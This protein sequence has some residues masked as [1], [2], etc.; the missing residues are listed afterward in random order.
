MACLPFQG[1]VDI[2]AHVNAVGL[3][4][5]KV[6]FYP[7]QS[8]LPC[9]ACDTCILNRVPENISNLSRSF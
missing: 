3:L 6:R 5:R 1:A 2:R 9:L 4:P 7:P 8:I